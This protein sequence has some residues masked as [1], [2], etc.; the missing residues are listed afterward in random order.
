MLPSLSGASPPPL[1][2]EESHLI[3]VPEIFPSL[4]RNESPARNALNPKGKT[5]PEPQVHI[6]KSFK[7]NLARRTRPRDFAAEGGIVQPPIQN[8]RL[9]EI[10]AEGV[11]LARSMIGGGG[12]RCLLRRLCRL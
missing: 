8:G 12:G 10:D 9:R 3:R 6:Y 2:V 11:D 4:A 1:G 7:I 5:F